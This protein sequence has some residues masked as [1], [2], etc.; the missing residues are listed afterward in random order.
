MPLGGRD[1]TRMPLPQGANPA[2]SMATHGLSAVA[3]GEREAS[4]APA[5]SRFLRYSSSRSSSRLALSASLSHGTS[6]KLDPA[7]GRAYVGVP[8]PGV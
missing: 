4:L 6:H 3:M 7:D 5:G 8:T 1:T 2:E